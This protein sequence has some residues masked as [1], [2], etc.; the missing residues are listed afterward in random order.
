[1][2][3]YV[4]L[5]NNYGTFETDSCFVQIEKRDEG[6]LKG[7][8]AGEHCCLDNNGYHYGNTG[9]IQC[10]AMKKASRANMLLLIRSHP[11]Q[12]FIKLR[13]SRTEVKLLFR[14]FLA[15]QGSDAPRIS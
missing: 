1:M 9:F 15:T 8:G 2:N 4:D 13:T 6:A 12:L 10:F 14:K 3:K 11:T 7:S 5:K